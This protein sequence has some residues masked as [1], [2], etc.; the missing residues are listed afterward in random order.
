MAKTAID[1][2]TQGRKNKV[3]KRPIELISFNKVLI[4]GKCPMG[5][6]P[7]TVS[8]FQYHQKTISKAWYEL[9]RWLHFFLKIKNITAIIIKINICFGSDK[10]VH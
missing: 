5:K 7:P 6:C 1:C 2:G 4:L 9:D 10:S 3:L 8:L